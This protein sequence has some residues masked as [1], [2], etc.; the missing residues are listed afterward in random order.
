[1]VA[2]VTFLYS[3]NLSPLYF[4]SSAILYVSVTQEHR[5]KYVVPEGR[6]PLSDFATACLI[7]TQQADKQDR[8]SGYAGRT[9]Q[10]SW[11]DESHGANAFVVKGGMD[12]Y[13]VQ[14]AAKLP[15][16]MVKT[17][18]RV[19]DVIKM[20]D[21]S[22]K[23]EIMKRN[24][25]DYTPLCLTCDTVVLAAPPVSLRRLSVA[26]DMQ[27]ALFAVHQRRLGHVYVKCNGNYPEIPDRSDVDDRYY[28][29]LPDSIL[30]QLISGDYG[31][32]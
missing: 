6:A 3:L 8:E 17:N 18:H 22:Y 12:Q 9:A 27:P 20:E 24:G 29:K 2:Y 7:G 23:I 5:E 14:L 21:G 11:P 1:M 31:K 15:E 28:K 16:G 13:P 26:V 25:N 32:G 30:Q 19:T 10:I 4:L